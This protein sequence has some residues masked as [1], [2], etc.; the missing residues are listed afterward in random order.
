MAHKPIFNIGDIICQS[1]K[2]EF[3]Y[4]IREIK[5]GYY[6]C[7]T[8]EFSID[9]KTLELVTWTD[10][11][12]KKYLSSFV[13]I[14]SGV[15]LPPDVAKKILDWIDKQG[16]KGTNGKNGNIP[17]VVWSEDDEKK[18]NYLIALL[19][20]S[21]MTNAALSATN[22]GI[23]DFLKS[24]K[25]R[26]QLQPKQERSKDV[27]RKLNRLYS[28]I[29]QAADTHAFSTTCRLIGDKEAI[30][31]QEFLKGIKNGNL[32]QSTQ[33]ATDILIDKIY[34]WLKQNVNKYLYNTGDDDVYIPSCSGKMIEDLKNYIKEESK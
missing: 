15:N 10:E 27:E 4:T 14:N 34:A 7:D 3:T 19:Q 9:N 13:E 25:D 11:R 22:E 21:T 29:G 1:D 12:I 31:L 18:L 8:C 20:N 32:S 23:E 17:F 16:E 5:D 24:L 33:E 26:V 6:I 30:E 2:P 28:I